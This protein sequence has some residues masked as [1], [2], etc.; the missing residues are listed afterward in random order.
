MRTGDVWFGGRKIVT[1]ING[2]GRIIPSRLTLEQQHALF[3]SS[4][5]TDGIHPL[6]VNVDSPTLRLYRAHLSAAEMR[7]RYENYPTFFTS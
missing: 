7:R 6:R 1:G 4:V 2:Y 5:E 3:T